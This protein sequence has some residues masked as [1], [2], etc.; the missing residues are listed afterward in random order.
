MV[1]KRNSDIPMYQKCIIIIIFL[2]I[3]HAMTCGQSVIKPNSMS[4][5]K[6]INGT[7]AGRHSWPWVCFVK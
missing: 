6:I 5:T 1:I 4:N 2:P 3:M 7:E